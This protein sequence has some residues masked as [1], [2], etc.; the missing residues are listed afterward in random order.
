M[1]EAAP[2]PTP[3][4]PSTRGRA[5]AAVVCLVLAAVADGPGIVLLLGTADHQRRSALR[6]DRGTP[7]GLAGGPDGDRREGHRRD[8]EAGRRRGAAQPG[9]RRGEPGP[10]AAAAPD[11]A[12]GGRGQRPDRDPG[13]ELHRLGRVPRAVARGECEGAASAPPRVGGRRL[14]SGI[15]T[16]RRGRPRP[17]DGHRPGQAAAR[18]PGAHIRPAL[19]TSPRPTSR[20]CCSSPTSWTRSRRSTPSAT[21][22]RSGSWRWSRC[23]ISVGCCC[24][25]VGRVRRW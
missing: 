3:A 12:A 6:G 5:I 15:R 20:S 24:P 7:R 8:R 22:W 21:R 1:A 9:L 4:E 19:R 10:S 14:G 13:A 23:C 2:V 17:L 18:R 25:A 11:R 16:E